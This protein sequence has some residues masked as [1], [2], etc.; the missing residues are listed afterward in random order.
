MH[1]HTHTYPHICAQ[2][3]SHISSIQKLVNMTVVFRYIVHK[4]VQT[5]TGS[6]EIIIITPNI[7]IPRTD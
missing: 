2:A 5:M 1:T 6:A 4:K 7:Q 3:Y